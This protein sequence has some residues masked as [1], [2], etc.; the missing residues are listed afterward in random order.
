[1][2]V[3]TSKNAL[4]ALSTLASIFVLHVISHV[5]NL[6]AKFIAAITIQTRVTAQS[7]MLN[8]CIYSNKYNKKNTTRSSSE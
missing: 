1:M 7:A 3:C 6:Y 5:V 8:D 2:S 4:T